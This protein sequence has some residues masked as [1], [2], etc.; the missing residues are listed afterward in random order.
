MGDEMD[1]ITEKRQIR[2][3]ILAVR[4]AMSAEERARGSLL[5]TER[6][7]GHQWYYRAEILLCFVSYGSEISTGA[8]LEEALRAGKSVFAPKVLS[9]A[10]ETPQMQFFKISSQD[11]LA[12]GYRGIP[13]PAGTTEAYPYS[14]EAAE[15]TLMLMPGAAFDLYRTR[16]GYGKGFYDRYLADRPALQERTIAVGYRCQM[17]E[18]LPRQDTDIRPV[19]VICV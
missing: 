1:I 10:Q 9:S 11:E 19:Q 15:R 16:L 5:L 4:D 6:I 13:E 12:P 7:L 14:R 2:K 3:K 8:I 18:K 17:A